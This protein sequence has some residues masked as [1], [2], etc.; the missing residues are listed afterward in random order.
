MPRRLVSNYTEMTVLDLLLATDDRTCA[1]TGVLHYDE[2][3]LL[4]RLF[5][6]RANEVYDSINN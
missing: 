3:V 6:N 5:H 4:M 2:D 1:D